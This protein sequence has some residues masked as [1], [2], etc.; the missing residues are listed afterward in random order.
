MKTIMMLMPY[1]GRW[2]EWMD[3]YIETCK[4][5]PT[6]DWLFFTDCGEPANRAVNVQYANTTLAEVSDLASRKLGCD[7]NLASAT[8]VCDLRPAYGKLFEDYTGGY[9]YWGHGDIDVIYGDLRRFLTDDL[10]QYNSLSFHRHRVSGHF[11]LYRNCPEMNRKYLCIQGW[12]GKM[13]SPA[14]LAL[15]EEA[16]YRVIGEMPPCAMSRYVGGGLRRMG[17]LVRRILPA[18]VICPR[19]N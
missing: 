3:L 18:L 9:D 1:F 15:D 4:A 6:V 2:P 12:H 5:N 17:R 19:I 11:C 7:V 8:K 14:L 10:L 16:M 13:R